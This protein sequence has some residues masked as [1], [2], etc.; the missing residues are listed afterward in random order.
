[1]IEEMLEWKV[2]KLRTMLEKDMLLWKSFN[3]LEN[4]L[5]VESGIKSEIWFSNTEYN[6]NSHF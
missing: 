2:R 6:S 4:I 5:S 1:M 3:S